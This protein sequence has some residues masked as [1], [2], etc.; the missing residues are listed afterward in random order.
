[1]IR[2]SF[3][4]LMVLV[5]LQS[6]ENSNDGLMPSVTGKAFEIVVVMEEEH[7]KSEA[8]E[9]LRN[10]LGADMDGMIQSEP[11]F[12]LVQIPT[13]AFT[14]IFRT[15]RNILRV[16]ISPDNRKKTLLF[17]SN[18]YAQPQLVVDIKAGTPQELKAIVESQAEVIYSKFNDMELSRIAKNYLNYEAAEIG[19]KLREKH[20][21]SM[22]FP[23]GYRYDVDQKDFAWISHES[24]RHSQGVLIYHYDYFS[25]QAFS[26]DSLIAR[27][28]AFLKKYVPGP[29][30]GTY[31]ITTETL[32]VEYNEF[33]RDSVYYAEL[34]G[35]WELAGP[36][37]MGGPFVSLS[38]VDPYRNRVL[39]VE[40]FVY[41]PREE[42]RNY[43]RQLEGI[44]RS[45]TIVKPN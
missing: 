27:R 36:D 23:K 30:E 11:L 2:R 15:H 40:G 28:N 22:I 44:L 32:P 1:M 25:E 18:V 9:A 39:C 38:R 42:K 17:S 6:C 31:M 21:I 5:G 8:G 20:G 34:R 29:I 13:R 3:F 37:F 33:I 16:G 41:A 14:D 24:A 43:I 7:W 35:L 4:I 12:T 10:L 19:S 45:L 26:R